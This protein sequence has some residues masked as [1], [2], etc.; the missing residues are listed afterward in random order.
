MSNYTS[1]HPDKAGTGPN[2]APTKAA[3]TMKTGTTLSKSK[4]TDDKERKKKEQEDKDAAE[5]EAWWPPFNFDNRNV[6]KSKI[7][8][9]LRNCQYDLFRTIA[10]KELGWRVVDHRNKVIDL[11]ILK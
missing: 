10:L 8:L 7:C 5:V 2:T 11:E 6:L 9:N 1:S 4:K 3:T